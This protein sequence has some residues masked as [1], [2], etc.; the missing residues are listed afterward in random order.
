MTFTRSATDSKVWDLTATT[1]PAEGTIT[2]SVISQIRFNDNGSFNVIGGGSNALTF[3][4]NGISGAQSV[5]VDLGTSGQFDGVA[6]LGEATTVAA[7]DQDGYGS[8]S[9][10]NVAFDTDGNLTG[11]YSNGQSEVLSTLRISLFPNEGGL[12]RVADTLFVESP[13][14]DD[15]IATTAGAAGAGAVRPGSLENSNVDIAREFVN[16]IEAQRGFQ[17]N[18]RVITTTDEMLA[19]LMNV[20]R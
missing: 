18:S 2:Q 4:W 10:L 7:T 14:S 17:A 16:L 13:N 8:G 3:A 19:E 20:V 11:F 1:D 12:L 5:L 15:A 9:L 6:M